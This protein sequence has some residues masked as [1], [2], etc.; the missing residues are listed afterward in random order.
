[1]DGTYRGRVTAR[2]ALLQSLNAP[3]V[4]LLGDEHVD[5]FV[6]LLRNGGLATLDR[7]PQKYGLP[8]IL[9]SGEVRLVD[10]TN[11]Y[12]TLA[13]EGRHKPIRIFSNSA[14][15][16]QHSALSSPE[17]KSLVTNIL[18][19]LRRPDMPRAWQAAGAPA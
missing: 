9:G 2:D 6:A 10:L 16:T 18:T 7:D 4:H 12:A 19:E 13:Q 11:L 17:A 1:Y 3:A 14:L 15:S 8:L 5:E